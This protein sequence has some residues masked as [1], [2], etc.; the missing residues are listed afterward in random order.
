MKHLHKVL[1]P[2]RSGSL[3]YLEHSEMCWC[4]QTCTAAPAGRGTHA[5]RR[6]SH[7]PERP[8]PAPQADVAAM[9]SGMRPFR[10]RV[11]T[12]SIFRVA[13]VGPSSSMP[14]AESTSARAQCASRQ[15]DRSRGGSVAG[16]GSNSCGVAVPWAALCVVAVTGTVFWR[17]VGIGIADNSRRGNRKQDREAE[18]TV[19]ALTGPGAASPSRC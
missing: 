7:S 3:K 11:F 18:L 5:L 6:Y 1:V 19:P 16:V 8:K 13:P 17:C 9:R 2:G 15:E 14:G 12:I 10:V 4:S